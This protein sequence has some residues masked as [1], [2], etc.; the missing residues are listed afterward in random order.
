MPP[1]PV[2]GLPVSHAHP[3][4][5]PIGEDRIITSGRGKGW[6]GGVLLAPLAWLVLA[7]L[8]VTA[9]IAFKP[10][11]FLGDPGWG[12]DSIIA[13]Y[14]DASL[15]GPAANSLI[16]A[17]AAALLA[18]VL[19]TA[20]AFL[21]ERCALRAPAALRAAFVLPMAIPPFMLAMGWSLLLSP[22]TGSINMLLKNWFGLA[23]PLFNISSMS[24]MIFVEALSLAPSAF[25]VIAPAMRAIDA[26][27][28]EAA[29]LNG[30]AVRRLR[31]VNLPLL[32]PALLG[33]FLYLFIVSLMVFDIPGTIGM[34]VGIEL[35]STRMYDMV[36]NAPTGL[37]DYGGISALS[38][39][40]I[41]LL[42][43]ACLLYQRLMAR[44]ARFVTVTGKPAR[45]RRIDLRGWTPVAWAGIALYLLIAVVLPVATI[46]WTSLL[47]YPMPPGAA[48]LAQLSRQQHQAVAADP[49]IATAAWHSLS[50]ALI[51][52]CGATLLGLAAG[53]V[54]VRRGGMLGRGI[55]LL[56]FLPLALPGVLIGTSLANLYL[57]VPWMGMYGRVGIIA[58][59][60]LTVYLSF[61]SRSLNAAIRQLHPDLEAASALCGASGSRTAWRILA[62]LA[63][64]ALAAT[65][66][67]VFAHSLREL[68]AALLL[69]GRDNAT[70]P[71]L[72]FGAWSQ[73]QAGRAAAVGLWLLLILLALVLAGHLLARLAGRARAP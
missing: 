44:A 6:L 45:I 34:P 39:M 18:M 61:A 27:L 49:M 5:R 10:S 41:L 59:A 2:A 56:A 62:P 23:T 28:E 40:A 15:L 47:P 60:H 58:I 71:T 22:R 66:L 53:W 69:Q 65:F 38:L 67:W 8:I 46:A 31:R 17:T 26:A 35:L 50:I 9:L 7:P 1:G 68:S 64:P 52:A 4:L 16:F 48:A 51:A 11:G 42:T 72:L 32:R 73:G 12:F 57:A 54:A 36:N 30:G 63:A 55:D 37:P 20:L 21:T 43:G 19:G 3:R 13:V 70:L 25:I 24:G 29:I 14:T 33:A